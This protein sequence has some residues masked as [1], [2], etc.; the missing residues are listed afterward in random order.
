MFKRVFPLTLVVLLA[1]SNLFAQNNSILK[2]QVTDQNKALVAGAMITLTGDQ[3]QGQ[4]TVISDEDGN[5][6]FLGLMPGNYQVLVSKS[7]FKTL[8]QD[9]VQLRA[10]QTLDLNIKLEVGEAKGTVEIKSGEDTPIVDTANPEKNYNISGQFLTELPLNSRQSWEALWTMVPGVGGF[11]DGANFDPVVNGAGSLNSG[12]SSGQ[13]II[14]TVSNNYTLNGF[15]IGNSFTNQGWRTQFS[16]E[17]IQDVVVKTAGADASTSAALGGSVNIV[18][19]SGGNK[20]SGSAGIFFQP[21]KFNWTN[22]PNGTSSTLTL[23]Q[24]DFSFGGP[25]ILPHFGEGTP[26]LWK[27]K[28]RLWFFTTYRNARTNTGIARS[29]TQLATFTTLGFTP[30]D[31][32]VLERSHRFTG[33]VSYQAN[34]KH[35]FVFNYLNDSGNTIN[36]NATAASLVESTIRLH[37]GGPTYQV[38]WTGNLSSNFLWTAQ[39]GHRAVDQSIYPYDNEAPVRVIWTSTTFSGGNRVGQSPQLVVYG[40]SNN[41]STSLTQRNHQE[42][43]TDV[44]WLQNLLGSHTI[45]AGFQLR[46]STKNVTKTIVPSSRITTIDE[47]II[48]GVRTPFRQFSWLPGDFPE[49]ER[50]TAQKGFY[51]QD[52]F[53]LNSRISINFGARFDNQRSYD[54]FDVERFAAWTTN[55]RLGFAISL[56]KGGRDVIRGSWGRYSDILTVNATPTV[57]GGSLASPSFQNQYDNSTVLDG[58]LETTVVTS[59]AGFSLPSGI[60]GTTLSEID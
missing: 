8:R 5:Y 25:I 44:T 37:E 41:A 15:N 7:G 58:I 29:A 6:N 46:P 54:Q 43:T 17:A 39:Y 32:D 47:V 50:S 13:G 14:N 18:T 45:Q 16:T 38:A 28:D 55:P 1:V 56:N 36:S 19:K 2:G 24:P 30:P 40:N 51:L 20:Y 26:M 52:K 35:S 33:K 12:A 59:N 10:T 4:K 57:S 34:S 21:S 53:R 49:S 3:V 22:V 31:F 23:Y 48:N 9:D 60:S 11:P 27:G 42:F